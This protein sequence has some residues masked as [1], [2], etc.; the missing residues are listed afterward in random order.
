MGSPKPSD[1]AVRG[2]IWRIWRGIGLP[3][4]E[5]IISLRRK[6]R[7]PTRRWTDVMDDQ[8]AAAFVVA[9]A[10]R[11]AVL[12]DF[13][14][15]LLKAQEQGTTLAEFRKDFDAIVAKH[16]WRYKGKRG[17]RTRTIF[18]TNMASSQA[19]G[20]WAQIERVKRWRP[21]LMYDALMDGRTR[22]AHAGWNGT[23]AK[24][25]DP[26]WERIYPPNGFNYRCTVRSLSARE[27]RERGQD[28]DNPTKPALQERAVAVT[29]ELTVSVPNG[30]Q[31]GFDGNVGRPSGGRA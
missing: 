8:H 25:D 31:A 18:N 26:V 24:V 22:L 20:R 13:M 9:G 30:V 14:Q 12:A 4:E 29:P 10:Q 3:F 15:S 5:A 27:V 7:I 11:D 16:G 19:T 2:L 28:P 6:V 23:I 1:R 17:W 21:Y